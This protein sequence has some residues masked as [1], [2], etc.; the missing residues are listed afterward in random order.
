MIKS[1]EEAIAD[2][3]FAEA[4]YAA[5][6]FWLDKKVPE[7][8]HKEI[9]PLLQSNFFMFFSINYGHLAIDDM[10][11]IFHEPIS[12]IVQEAIND[13]IAAENERNKPID[14]KEYLYGNK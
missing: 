8:F 7:R 2:G 10:Q 9:R 14:P 13:A 6:N 5:A 4:A 1:I 3:N 11:E 12:I